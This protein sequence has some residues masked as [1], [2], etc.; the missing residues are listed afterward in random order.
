M[1]CNSVT[2]DNPL[3]GFD[4]VVLPCRSPACRGRC[5]CVCLFCVSI[6]A[7]IYLC[8]LTSIVTELFFCL[9][10]R[11]YYYLLADSS[12]S[13]VLSSPVCWLSVVVGNPRM[14]PL[15]AMSCPAPRKRVVKRFHA[16]GSSSGKQASKQPTTPTRLV[17]PAVAAVPPPSTT[18]L[19]EIGC[20]RRK[21]RAANGVLVLCLVVLLLPRSIARCKWLHYIHTNT[22]ERM[23]RPT[24]FGCVVR[25]FSLSETLGFFRCKWKPAMT[26]RHG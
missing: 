14:A 13:R 7:R 3:V 2:S 8:L 1:S 10:C 23:S 5:R 9:A 25:L 11:C 15:S 6:P 19:Q 24:L 20:E 22:R 21:E 18:T 17:S 16:N 26:R 12:S 4:R